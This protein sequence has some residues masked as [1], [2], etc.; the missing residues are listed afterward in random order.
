MKIKIIQQHTLGDVLFLQKA[1][2][3]ILSLNHEVYLPTDYSWVG[4]YIKKDGLYFYDSSVDKIINFH[5]V[6]EPNHPYD[7]MTYKYEIIRK[8]FNLEDNEK[9][10]WVNWQKHMKFNRNIQRENEIYYDILNLKDNEDYILKNHTLSKGE[11][12][13]FEI[14]TKHKTVE[15]SIIPGYSM[16]D[17]SKVIENAK[18]IWTIDTAIN[19]LIESINTRA[20]KLVV[21]ARHHDTKKALGHIW[22]KDWEWK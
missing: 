14:D 12:R 22:N 19:Y 7:I 2:D 5:D 20:E 10:S 4:D 11:K 13:H 18:E 21:F 8:T 9:N 1:I 15:I 17:W 6:I 16:F 3:I